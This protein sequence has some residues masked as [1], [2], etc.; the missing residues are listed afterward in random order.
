MSKKKPLLIFDCDGTLV[1]SEIVAS[2]VFPKVWA[3]MGVNIT[4]DFFLCNFVGTGHDAEIVKKTRA[5]LPPGGMDLSD[6]RFLEAL[7]ASVKPVDGVPGILAKIESSEICVASNSSI[8]YIEKVLQTCSLSHHFAD[9]IYS[10]HEVSKAKPSPDLFL[11]AA[12][13]LET[14]P[15]DCV[16]IEDSAFGI[17]A[18]KRAG[19]RVVG[20]FGG[21][22]CNQAVRDKVL[23]AGADEYAENSEELLAILLKWKLISA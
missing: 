8:P 7:Y 3:E 13:D 14:E 11:Y 4:P 18:A 10:A 1:D 23:L 2:Q 15:N 19:M 22:H 9:R 12:K 6:Q 5:Q 20:F 16:V 17:E 21:Q